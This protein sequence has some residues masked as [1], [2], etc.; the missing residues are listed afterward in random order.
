LPLVPDAWLSDVLGF[1][2]F[3]TGPAGETPSSGERSLTYTKVPVEATQTVSDLTARGFAVVD[4]NVTLSRNKNPLGNEASSVAVGPASPEQGEALADIAGS[5]FR[6]SRFHLDPLLPN[7]LADR[8]KR[9]WVM[10]YVEGRRGV[11][12]L[13]A[14]KGDQPAGFLAVLASGEA[15]VIDLVGVSPDAQRQGIGAA[16]V[17]AFVERHAPVAAELRAGTQIANVPSLRLYERLGFSIS[18]AAYVLHL[19]KGP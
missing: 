15:R 13:A 7:E 4:V 1:P 11:E 5:C 3:A 8:V 17:S 19:H 2:V 18:S 14:L 6:Y 16:L 9:A 10:S 12:L